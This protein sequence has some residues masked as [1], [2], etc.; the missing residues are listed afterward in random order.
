MIIKKVIA[1]FAAATIA[2]AAIGTANAQAKTTASSQAAAFVTHLSA[3]KQKKGGGKKHKHGGKKHK[4][5]RYGDKKYKKHRYGGKKHKYKYG[6]MHGLSYG[7]GKYVIHGRNYSTWRGG[8]Y[9][10]RY[11]N[12]W[13]TFV[14]LAALTAILIG[15]DHYYPNAYISAPEDYCGGVTE[16]GCEL[17]WREVETIEGD[18][19]GQCV[20]YCPWEN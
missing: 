10:V 7:H 5:H 16:D 11:N 17:R 20:A 12:R 1:V 9:R 14:P 3:K 18:L 13:V 15:G 4:K 8:R 2:I 6:R 19:V